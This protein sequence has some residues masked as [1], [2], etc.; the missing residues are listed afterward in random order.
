MVMKKEFDAVVESRK[1][2]YATGKKL[3]AMTEEER[4]AY[5]N[6]G[7]AEKLQALRKETAASKTRRPRK[8]TR[9]HVARA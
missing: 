8:P 1:W 9:K 7:I 3:S 5:L 6:H 2:R 4:L